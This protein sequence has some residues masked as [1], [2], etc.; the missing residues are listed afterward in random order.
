MP[1]YRLYFL[2]EG[3]HVSAPAKI[4][5]CADNEE[6]VQMA[7]QYIDGKD[8]QLWREGTLVARLPKSPG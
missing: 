3:A 5:H 4:L 6:A 1:T 8:I 2:D 7:R